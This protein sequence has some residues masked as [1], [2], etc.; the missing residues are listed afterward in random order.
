MFV[1]ILVGLA[2]IQVLVSC[3]GEDDP[4]PPEKCDAL[5]ELLC[6]RV[7]ECADDGTTQDEC[8][9]S[10]KTGL[11]CAQADAVSDGYDSCL[12]EIEASPC[13]VIWSDGALHLPATCNQTILFRQ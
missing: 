6:E 13:S 10:V 2:L 11:P 4:S 5:V 9:A 7:R 8:V 3:G 12:N 1:R